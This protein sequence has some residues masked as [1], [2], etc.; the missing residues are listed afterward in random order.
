[1]RE[2]KEQKLGGTSSQGPCLDSLVQPWHAFA[3]RPGPR[4]P[5]AEGHASGGS[6][7][8]PAPSTP[9]HPHPRTPPSPPLQA[10]VK[11]YYLQFE[12]AEAQSMIESR[13]LE[14][15]QRSR[16]VRGGWGGCPRLP[17]RVG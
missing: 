9:P 4:V 1:M 15:Q 7:A 5:T 11:S 17:R 16:M 14:Y 12:E 3:V 10:N 6:S 8:S 2:G 13:I